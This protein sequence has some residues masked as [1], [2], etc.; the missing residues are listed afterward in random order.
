MRSEHGSNPCSLPDDA[1][2]VGEQPGLGAVG[3]AELVEHPGHVALDGRLR[4]VQAGRR[5]GRWRGPRP[6]R[7]APRARARS[8]TR[9]AAVP[10]GGSTRRSADAATSRRAA[11]GDSTMF[12]SAATRTSPISSSGG[13]DLTRNP[14]A[15]ARSA[16]STYW[17]A[18]KVVSAT[19]TGGSG[20][21][22]IRSIA[23]SPSTPGM[24]RSMS[25]TSGRSRRTASTAAAPSWASLDDLQV[26]GGAEDRA[27]VRADHRLVVDDHHPDGH[28]QDPAAGADAAAVGT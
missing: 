21:S 22:L 9:P 17:S 15:P 26:V 10:A 12:P 16:R 25:T 28:G 8:A 18:S 4:Q 24:R 11:A 27:Q 14:A 13:V 7:R 2:V 1:G 20:S 5:S 19:T 23:V 6:G 3:A